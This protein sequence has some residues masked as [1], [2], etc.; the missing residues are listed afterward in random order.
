MVVVLRL[1]LVMMAEV[2]GVG[3]VVWCGDD[4][5]VGGS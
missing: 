3:V 5:V 2:I 4:V 1:L